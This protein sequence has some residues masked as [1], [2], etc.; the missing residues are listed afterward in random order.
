LN[1]G[2]MNL[3]VVP[4]KTRS[5]KKQSPS[6]VSIE[7]SSFMQSNRVQSVAEDSINV[8]KIPKIH[9]PENEETTMRQMVTGKPDVEQ[10]R[11]FLEGLTSFE[12]EG[13]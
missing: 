10:M 2:N 9:E 1:P 8:I 3:M 7:H 6:T 12:S 5:L 11:L 4:G 13:I